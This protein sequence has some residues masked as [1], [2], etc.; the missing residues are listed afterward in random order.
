M[1]YIKQN[2]SKINYQYSIGADTF[3]VSGIV[4]SKCSY[5]SPVIVRDKQ[6]LDIY[7]GK[8]FPERNYFIELLEMGVSLLLYKPVSSE[9]RILSEYLDLTK[10][11]EYI[12]SREN[13]EYFPKGGADTE[14]QRYIYRDY[15][16]KE[17]YIWDESLGEYVNIKNLPQNLYLEENYLSWYNRDTLRLCSKD[18]FEYH[19]K[20]QIDKHFE[21]K[22]FSEIDYVE[23]DKGLLREVH[24]NFYNELDEEI[25]LYIKPDKDTEH[26]LSLIPGNNC[27]ESSIY[28]KDLFSGGNFRVSIKFDDNSLLENLYWFRDT[29]L[30]DLIQSS[31]T[32]FSNLGQIETVLIT[33]EFN[34]N[35]DN[36]I[37]CCYPRYKTDDSFVYQGQ[38]LSQHFLENPSYL[39]EVLKDQ[40]T[41]SFKFS[42]DKSIL[43]E[44][45]SYICIPSPKSNEN[46]LILYY[47]DEE[48]I[49]YPFSSSLIN[50]I[51]KINIK[52]KN[53]DEILEETLIKFQD[54]GYKSISSLEN[55]LILYSEYGTIIS[56][57]FTN[58]NGII[59]S[60]NQG[61][62]HDI[63]SQE[64]E[65]YKRIEFYS[66]TIGPS[67]DNIKIKIEEVDYRE[68][69]YKITVSRFG[70][71]EIYEGNLYDEP[72]Q[73]GKIQSLDS[74]IN[75]RS[76]L[77]EC[78]LFRE[79]SNGSIWRKGDI[80]GKL[81]IGEWSLKR[82]YSEQTSSSMY[83]ESLEH[84]RNFEVKEDFILIPEIER[85]LNSST[86]YDII[87]YFPEYQD[88]LNYCTEKNCQALIGNLNFGIKNEYPTVNESPEERMIYNSGG[89][90][91]V[92][93]KGKY[94]TLSL[95]SNSLI[96]KW[97][98]TF[99]YNY[100]EDY[101]NRLVFF[102]RDMLLMGKFP[103]PAYYIFL[104]GILTGVYS[105]TSLK[106]IYDSPL[107]DPYKEEDYEKVF[108]IKKSN[109]LLDNGQYFFYKN[110]QN[111]PGNGV[112]NTT[113]L[114][115]FAVGKV[116]RTLE[117]NKW[118]FLG[119]Q[120]RGDIRKSIEGLLL[121]L[122]TK[123]SL[124]KSISLIDFQIDHSNNS[125][126][127]RLNLQLKELV[128]KPV[129]LDIEL[130]Y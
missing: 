43:I 107:I 40:R 97:G 108:T 63:L 20:Y 31:K 4:D 105:L 22:I 109:Y 88:L 121:K 7:F 51:I 59:I 98:N 89:M 110:Y 120:L 30:L 54:L 2:T 16:T 17:N 58:I 29:S 10:F 79:K 35:Y 118:V 46:A 123:Y 72:D 45:S 55:S 13:P 90:Y 96:L 47:N 52:D 112:Y 68:D 95:S 18:K 53:W 64:T 33:G 84:L 80:A 117:N 15:E 24:L 102:Y 12:P 127:I 77:I 81:P 130:N 111:H 37:E 91:K 70:Y 25:K 26:F 48:N 99:I 67:E 128:D 27:I 106:L 3:I 28:L 119:K 87:G 69:R 56:S 6:S 73:D 62:T 124:Y 86:N 104:K 75:E 74:I 83:W 50:K 94:H 19:N 92:Y 8:S 60:P 76:R 34:S 44:N 66:K 21:D 93:W 78:R 42:F 38:S 125:I 14:E 116:S 39:K 41:L 100:N 36:P 126:I 49:K 9:K 65:N 61:I 85:F 82:A 1:P 114:T 129:K 71:S 32:D 115:R 101:D 11:L 122:K 23:P 5:K 113:I 103:R 57:S